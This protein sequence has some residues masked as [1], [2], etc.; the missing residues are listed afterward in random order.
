MW[1]KIMHKQWH[2]LIGWKPRGTWVK[3]FLVNKT[4]FHL[5]NCIEAN[6]FEAFIFIHARPMANNHYSVVSGWMNWVFD[7][8]CKKVW[9]STLGNLLNSKVWGFNMSW[10]WA[11]ATMVAVTQSCW[12]IHMREFSLFMLGGGR[13]WRDGGVIILSHGVPWWHFLKCNYFGIP[14]THCQN[15]YMKNP[16]AAIATHLLCF[17]LFLLL[18][19]EFC[20]VMICIR[21]IRGS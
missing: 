3:R 11:G 6:T 12:G 4:F 1:P 5:F 15:K 19:Y 21:C 9:Q 14:I 18:S 2:F 16:P 8:L 7:Q 17:L 13:S 10:L 20:L